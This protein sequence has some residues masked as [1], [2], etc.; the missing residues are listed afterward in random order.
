MRRSSY[1]LEMHMATW[2]YPMERLCGMLLPLVRSMQHPYT[3]LRNQITMW[4]QFSH[5]QYKSE[6]N[7]KV[8]GNR[9]EEKASNNLEKR[10]FITDNA[11]EELHSLSRK[12][13]M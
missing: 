13:L 3:N 2:Q 11:E 10:V 6:I 7:Q 5:L 12:Y 9:M 8:F 4:I 1:I